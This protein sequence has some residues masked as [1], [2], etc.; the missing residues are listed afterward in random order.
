MGPIVSEEGEDSEDSPV[1]ALLARLC[2]RDNWK[3]RQV[4]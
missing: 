4:F 1:W 3:D 2:L